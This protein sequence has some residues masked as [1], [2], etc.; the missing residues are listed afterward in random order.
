MNT[1]LWLPKSYLTQIVN[2][3]ENQ[4]SKTY[5]IS[6]NITQVA[7]ESEEQ[8]I[9]TY[10]AGESY[11]VSRPEIKIPKTFKQA[12]ESPDRDRWLDAMIKEMKAHTIVEN[13]GCGVS[14][15][16]PYSIH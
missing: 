4:V 8:L 9:Y 12:M 15:S 2:V 3:N 11:I 13:L 10:V 1:L 6:S 5:H 16:T 7:D 14:C